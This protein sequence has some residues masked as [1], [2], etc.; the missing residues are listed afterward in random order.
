MYR[1]VHIHVTEE[2][3]ALLRESRDPIHIDGLISHVLAQTNFG[4]M[5]LVKEYSLDLSAQ[6]WKHMPTIL[7]IDFQHVVRSRSIIINFLLLVAIYFL[8]RRYNISYLVALAF[9]GAYCLYQYL[10]YE[11]HKVKRKS[12]IWKGVEQFERRNNFSFVFISESNW[13]W[14]SILF[15]VPNG[16]HV[17]KHL[18]TTGSIGCWAKIAVAGV[19]SFWRTSA[20]LLLFLYKF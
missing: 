7:D 12:F 5:Q 19:E 14:R 18:R 20:F 6:L 13:I 9:A 10:D 2:Q 17:R 15:M 3:L 1:T 4:T 11:C 16:I 8:C